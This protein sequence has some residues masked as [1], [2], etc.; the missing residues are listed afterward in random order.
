MRKL[1][2]LA[3]AA[4]VS[5]TWRL[6]VETSQGTGRKQFLIAHHITANSG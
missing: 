6:T 3:M 4:D 2:S 1:S 5:G